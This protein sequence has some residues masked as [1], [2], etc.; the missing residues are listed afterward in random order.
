MIS[1]KTLI[2]V[3]GILVLTVGVLY[4]FWKHRRSLKDMRHLLLILAVSLAAGGLVELASNL[5]LL[6][7]K[8]EERGVQQLSGEDATLRGFEKTEDG[9][10]LTKTKG[11]VTFTFDEPVYVNKFR[12]KFGYDDVLTSKI[13]IKY[14]NKNGIM[15][16]K[17][18]EDVNRL[19][20]S[21]SVV[22]MN[23][24]VKSISLEFEDVEDEVRLYDFKID[25]EPFINDLRVLFVVAVVFCAGFLICNRV[26]IREHLEVGFL[27]V[28]LV[29]GSLFICLLPANKVSWDEEIHF[30]NSYYMSVG[31]EVDVT[32]PVRELAN[33]TVMNWPYELPQSLEEKTEGARYL[34]E[35]PDELNE[36]TASSKEPSHRSGLRSFGYMGSV[37]AINIGRLFH[38]PLSV[39]YYLG[40]MGNL[41]LYSVVMFFA[42]RRLALGKRILAVVGLMP[43]SIFLAC[44]YSCDASITAFLSL[45]LAYIISEFAEKDRE[46]TWKSFIIFMGAMILG[47]CPKAIYIPL[48]LLGLFLPKQKFRD[49]RTMYL[50]KGAIC[51]VCLL[52]LSTFVLPNLLN[53]S[54]LGDLRGG[55]TSNAGQISLMLKHPVNYMLLLVKSVWNTLPDYLAGTSTLTLLGHLSVQGSTVIAVAILVFTIFTDVPE[56]NRSLGGKTKILLLSACGVVIALIWTALYIEYTPVGASVI[57]GVQGRYYIPLLLPVFLVL[58]TT[59][60]HNHIGKEWYNTGVLMLSSALLVQ[61]M[62]RALFVPMCL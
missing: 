43:T 5:K 36:E 17:T 41:L 52:L 30:S 11:S 34:D 50:M 33:V 4:W 7:L 19:V 39:L 60:L 18:I 3:C 46:I 61:T 14:E 31:R 1:F 37:L 16:E 40:R 9:F 44:T 8:G 32:Q 10:T 26:Y 2:F 58:N 23:A 27:V 28:S 56:K 25:N 29:L 51:V 20:L 55:D 59:K 15:D 62:Y 12:Y 6:T 48:I 45:G 24:N 35:G 49:K 53:P 21:E 54:A 22:N 13:L 42:I 38:L 57:N 47:S